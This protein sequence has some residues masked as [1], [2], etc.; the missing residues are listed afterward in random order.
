MD[1]AL[2]TWSCDISVGSKRGG[3][4]GACLSVSIS[5][6]SEICWETDL[7]WEVKILEVAVL[8]CET[9]EQ[10]TCSDF[11]EG[12]RSVVLTLVGGEGPV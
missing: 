11:P 4:A 6:D 1:I 3:G 2:F 10:L 5:P 7:L 12:H 9:T 8:S